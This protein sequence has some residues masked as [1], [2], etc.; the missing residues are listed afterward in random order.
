MSETDPK[1]PVESMVRAAA[2]GLGGSRDEA[3]SQLAELWK[4]TPEQVSTWA[5]GAEPMP[6]EFANRLQM[7]PDDST[8]PESALCRDEWIMA[9]GPELDRGNRREYVIHAWPPRF[10]CRA[11]S[12][13]PETGL[14][15]DDEEPAHVLGGLTHELDELAILGEFHWL[16]PMP[17]EP[18]LSELLEAAAAT[19]Y[20]TA[21]EQ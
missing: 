5:S 21:H 13:D 8:T 2:A 9:E 19:L 20:D 4:A 11:I 6:P 18:E 3:I 15:E 12:I 14:P 17:P 16:D 7:R 1:T 10:V